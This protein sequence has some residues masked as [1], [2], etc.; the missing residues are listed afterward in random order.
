MIA[1]E[2]CRSGRKGRLDLRDHDGNTCCM[3]T[4]A[5]RTDHG[6][7]NRDHE[8]K[9]PKAAK[10]RLHRWDCIANVARRAQRG[11]V[12]MHRRWFENRISKRY[13]RWQSPPDRSKSLAVGW[14]GYP[15]LCGACVR[16]TSMERAPQ[17]K[18]GR[19]I[20]IEENG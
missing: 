20:L 9:N 10:P 3:L 2:V 5:G 11:V 13:R 1:I 12:A 8:K 4:T 7:G 18:T 6:A 17:R 19:R 14:I 16:K 15:F